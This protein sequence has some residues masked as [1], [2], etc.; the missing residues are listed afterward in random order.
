MFSKCLQDVWQSGVERARGGVRPNE[1]LADSG[2]PR[3]DESSLDATLPQLY[4]QLKSDDSFLTTQKCDGA[5]VFPIK[6][7]RWASYRHQ[8]S[9]PVILVIRS[10]DG[11]T[12]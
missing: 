3:L 9:D 6:N 7:R 1:S 5:E 10:T 12:C 4:S 11:R 8:R 2:G